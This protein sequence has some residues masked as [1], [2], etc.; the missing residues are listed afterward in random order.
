MANVPDDVCPSRTETTNGTWANAMKAMKEKL[1]KVQDK[2][3]MGFLF[4]EI[5]QVS[6]Y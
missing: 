2:L 5:T 1:T 3:G 6:L 4:D